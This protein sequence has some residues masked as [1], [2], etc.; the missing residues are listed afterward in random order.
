LT[1]TNGKRHIVERLKLQ[2][3]NLIF[4]G[5]GLN[6]LPAF[7]LVTRFVGYGGSFYRENIAARCD[8]YIKTPTMSPLLPL[9]LMA[10]ECKK[11]TATE[12]LTY[13]KGLDLII[14][15]KVSLPL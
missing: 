1:Q 11:L 4:V 13:Q 14:Q 2:Y 3:P 10:E 8:F 15:D 5:D 7:D 9:S 6:D 12:Q